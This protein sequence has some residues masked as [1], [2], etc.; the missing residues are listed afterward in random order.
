MVNLLDYNCRVENRLFSNSGLQSI[1]EPIH[2]PGSKIDTYH[3]LRVRFY[4]LLKNTVNPLPND[5]HPSFATYFNV[6]PKLESS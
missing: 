4:L 2:Y 3:L 1:M 5:K 6:H